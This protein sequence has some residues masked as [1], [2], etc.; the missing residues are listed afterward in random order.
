M[1][2]SEELFDRLMSVSH[3]QRRVLRG[4]P[5]F[6][7]GD[8]VRRLLAVTSGEVHLTRTLPDGSPLILQ[9]AHA[10]AV[11]AEAS[12]YSERYHCDAFARTE[13]QL[14]EFDAAE[15]RSH[16]AADTQLATAWT[17]TLA[18]QVQSARQLSEIL[19]LKTVRERL[20]AWLLANDGAAPPTWKS[21]ADEIGVSPAAL[22][23]EISR[24]GEKSAQTSKNLGT[25]GKGA[26]FI[27]R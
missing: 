25:K 19:R 12:L 5:L 4:E 18:R 8:H 7:A 9:R 13:A 23:R 2:M 22:Y 24:R 16:L 3:R 6:Y 17:K 10:P 20:D 1:I 15:L 11:L 27:R 21:V 14:L 26:A